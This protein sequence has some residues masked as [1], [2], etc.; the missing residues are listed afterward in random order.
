MPL[1]KKIKRKPKQNSKQDNLI[2]VFLE[3]EEANEHTKHLNQ[4]YEMNPSY[5]NKLYLDTAQ[6]K[7]LQNDLSLGLAI[8]EQH[9][10]LIKELNKTSDNLSRHSK[11]KFTKKISKL[12]SKLEKAYESMELLQD[13][14]ENVID[15]KNTYSQSTF[16]S[17]NYNF[18]NDCVDLKLPTAPNHML[19]E[20]NDDSSDN[21]DSNPASLVES[22]KTEIKTITN[23][24]E[25]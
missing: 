25:N 20:N 2:V 7:V 1:F 18:E 19:N 13:E 17:P 10:N 3:R 11:E 4:L 22:V 15:T 9:S 12:E 23:V 6:L 24:S 5:L 14:F 21:N 8:E 16:Q